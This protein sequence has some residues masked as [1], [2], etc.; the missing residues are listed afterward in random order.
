MAPWAMPKKTWD[1]RSL[2]SRFQHGIFYAVIRA[3]GRGAAHAL[4]RPVVLW[5]VL[6]RP[7]VRAKAG[8]YLRRRFPGRKAWFRD[9]YRLCLG[10]GKALVDRAVLGI[11]GPGG[12]APRM[13]DA[14]RL[15]ALLAEGRGLIL[16]TAHVGGWQHAMSGLLHLKAPVSLLIHRDA[17]DV[18]KQ[19]FEHGDGAP[20][21]TLLDPAGYLGSTLEMLQVLGAGGV[22]CIMGDRGMGAATLPVDFLGGPVALPFSPYRLA[23]A[24]GAP[25]AVVFS[26]EVRGRSDLQLAGVIRVPQGLGRKAAA[27]LPYAREF[28]QALERFVAEHPYQ[29]FNFYDMWSQD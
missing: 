22:L 14:P 21:F 5:F 9:T 1:S 23:S 10:F 26:R 4:L 7:E 28:S 29:F 2:G 3:F 17:G 27:Y 18:D 25:I 11:L 24:T 8:P 19:F 20:P 16:V 12:V 6:F 15:E 13:D